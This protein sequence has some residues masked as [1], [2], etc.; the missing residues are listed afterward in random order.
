MFRKKTFPSQ[1]HHYETRSQ[2]C[3]VTE[4]YQ[5]TFNL[6]KWVFR[7][8]EGIDLIERPWQGGS[9]SLKQ[10]HQAFNQLEGVSS[11]YIMNKSQAKALKTESARFLLKLAGKRWDLRSKQVVYL[12]KKRIEM[13]KLLIIKISAIS[14]YTN[15]LNKLKFLFTE[16]K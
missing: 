2:Q 9:E 8:S 10:L 4:A 5:H 15:D 3:E 1:A 12:Q 7:T 16:F 6:G 11:L 14:I 13:R